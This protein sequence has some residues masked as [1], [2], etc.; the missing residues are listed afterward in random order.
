MKKQ[1]L[2]LVLQL[3]FRPP[4]VVSAPQI[5]LWEKQALLLVPVASAQASGGFSVPTK[6]VVFPS[7]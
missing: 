3:E 4:V 1:A 5:G 6:N 7:P 2:L